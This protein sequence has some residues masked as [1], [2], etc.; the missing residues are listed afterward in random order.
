MHRP[1]PSP[2]FRITK[3]AYGAM[4]AHCLREKPIEACGVLSGTDE[5]ALTCWPLPNRLQSPNAFEIDPADLARCLERIGAKGERLCAVYHSHPTARAVPSRE[6][7]R[8]APHDLVYL[9]VSLRTSLPVVRA[10][11]LIDGKAWP[12]ALVVVDG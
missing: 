1:F 3:S 6:D 4:I 10:Y 8:H 7:L 5:W 9:I 11:R 2:P 12:R